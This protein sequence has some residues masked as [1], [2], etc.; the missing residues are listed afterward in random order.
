MII[1]PQS[2][3]WITPIVVR[4]VVHHIDDEAIPKKVG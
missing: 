2:L 3:Q 4:G 1:Y